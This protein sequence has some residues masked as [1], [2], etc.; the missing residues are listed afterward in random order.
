MAKKKVADLIVDTLAAAGVERVY[1]VAGDSLNGITDAIRR[2]E[3]M[4]WIHVRH[5]ETAAFAAGYNFPFETGSESMPPSYLSSFFPK[6]YK[7]KKRLAPAKFKKWSPRVFHFARPDDLGPNAI[8]SLF[9][10][11]TTAVLIQCRGMTRWR[12]LEKNP[13]N[14]LSTIVRSDLRPLSSA[15]CRNA[16]SKPRQPLG[17]GLKL[18]VNIA[19]SNSIKSAIDFSILPT[20]ARHDQQA[21]RCV[22]IRAA[23]LS[24]SSLSTYSN[25]RSRG[26]C[27][28]SPFM[29]F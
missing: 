24:I 28:A 10:A 20:W 26:R 17:G 13:A 16:P 8:S 11:K 27:C 9:G 6:T 29:L 4:Q 19:P 5:E 23:S 25:N 18:G 21:P 2:Q 14:E 15:T 12:A 3:R 7:I 1:G 22:S